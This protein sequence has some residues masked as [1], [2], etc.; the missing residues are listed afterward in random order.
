[1]GALI[2]LNAKFAWL[3]WLAGSQIVQSRPRVAKE[4]KKGRQ[5]RQRQRQK[6]VMLLVKRTKMIVLHGHVRHAFEHFSSS[7]THQN[8]YVK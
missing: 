7:R 6:E 3:A 5:L 2:D 4:F 8:Y 1:M